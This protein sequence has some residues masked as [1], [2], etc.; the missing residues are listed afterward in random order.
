MSESVA[1][2]V[3]IQYSPTMWGNI[4]EWDILSILRDAG[5]EV[6]HVGRRGDGGVDIIARIKGKKFSFQCKNWSNKIEVVRALRGVTCLEKG[7]VGIVVGNE[8]S[9]GAI[10]EANLSQIHS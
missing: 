9:P 5:F 2:S 7:V 10:K 1:V 6:I 4:L 3:F 8:F